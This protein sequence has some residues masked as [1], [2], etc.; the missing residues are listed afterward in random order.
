MPEY[1]PT[2]IA[3]EGVAD[4][5]D[6]DSLRRC[7]EA[8]APTKAVENFGYGAVFAQSEANMPPIARELPTS[9]KAAQKEST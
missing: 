6:V 9:L 2:Y 3:I 8:L 4:N 1:K 5:E 7:L